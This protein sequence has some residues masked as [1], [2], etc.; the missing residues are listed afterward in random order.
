MCTSITFFLI[1]TCLDTVCFILQ[2]ETKDGI[3]WKKKNLLELLRYYLDIH[4]KISYILYLPGSM[5]C[6]VV[7]VLFKH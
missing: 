4:F 3:I 5:Y 1:S 2:D 7:H 6:L